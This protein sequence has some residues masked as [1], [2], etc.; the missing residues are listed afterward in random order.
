M[1]NG[2]TA[3]VKHPNNVEGNLIL[4]NEYISFK[5]AKALSI[6]TPDCGLC[7]LNEKSSFGSEYSNQLTTDKYA[8]KITPEH[9]GVCFYSEF[10]PYIFPFKPAALKTLLNIEDF[11]KMILFDH[12]IY[13]KDRHEGNILIDLKNKVF[14][15][16]DHSHVF[17]NQSL[18]DHIAFEQ[19]IKECDYKDKIIVQYNSDTYIPIWQAQSFDLNLAQTQANEFQTILTPQLIGDIINQI[20]E[21]WK[22]Y[23]SKKDLHALAEYLNYRINNLQEIVNIIFEAKEELFNEKN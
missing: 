6:K 3:V 22:N 19:G 15:A 2:K 12:I 11:Q 18:W 10:I 20:P 5:I 21:E 4:L 1:D 9:Y 14:Y 17:K 7:I 23:A 13:N 8:I 16:I